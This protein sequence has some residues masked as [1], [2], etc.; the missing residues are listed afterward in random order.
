[1]P[2][3]VKRRTVALKVMA[4]WILFM[5]WVDLYWNVLP[6]FSKHGMH[7]HWLD[8]ST[9]LGIGGIFVWHFWKTYRASSPVPVNDPKLSASIEF[10]NF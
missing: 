1:M 9:M 4:I 7:F 8:L 5:H 3:F 2:R 6:N 10:T